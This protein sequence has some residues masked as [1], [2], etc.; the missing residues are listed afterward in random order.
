MRGRIGIITWDSKP[1][2][3]GWGWD[4]YWSCAD[5]ITWHKELV[6]KFGKDKANQLWLTAWQ[7]QDPFESNYSWCKYDTAFSNYLKSQGIDVGHLLSKVINTGGNVIENVGEAADS[8]TKILKWVLPVALIAGGVLLY[9][10]LSQ[11]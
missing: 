11:K 3:D 5:W 2:Y 6:K 8:T 7:Q 10:N 1:D 9:N 4:D